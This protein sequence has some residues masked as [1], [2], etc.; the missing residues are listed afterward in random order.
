MMPPQRGPTF[1]RKAVVRPMEFY[2]EEQKLTASEAVGHM[3]KSLLF[4][5]DI[6]TTCD[7]C[8]DQVCTQV[9]GVQ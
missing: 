8:Q 7:S 6:D 9:A 3:D 5:A 2:Q 4:R 1:R